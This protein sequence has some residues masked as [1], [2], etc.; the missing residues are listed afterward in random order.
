MVNDDNSD[1]DDDY[2]DYD[3]YDNDNGY[4]DDDD[5]KAI[6]TRDNNNDAVESTIMMALSIITVLRLKTIMLSIITQ[7]HNNNALICQDEMT[8]MM[9]IIKLISMAVLWNATV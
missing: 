8:M 2:N 6:Y 3:N 4:D 5:N 9:S 7:D 1:D